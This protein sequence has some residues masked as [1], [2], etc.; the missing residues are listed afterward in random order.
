MGQR[1]FLKEVPPGVAGVHQADTQWEGG[2]GGNIPAKSTAC[3]K[4]QN[5]YTLVRLFI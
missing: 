4:A 3:A 2:L 5:V 1:K